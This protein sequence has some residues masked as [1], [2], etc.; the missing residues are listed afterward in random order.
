MSLYLLEGTPTELTCVTGTNTICQAH[1]GA[2]Y[3]L[4]LWQMNPRTRLQVKTK[5][6]AKKPVPPCPQEAQ[7]VMFA[8][9]IRPLVLGPVLK[10]NCDLHFRL[11]FHRDIPL[12]QH[13]FISP[14][15]VPNARAPGESV[16]PFRP[17]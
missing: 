1:K 3:E 10:K 9:M 11:I 17:E 13:E 4:Q 2:D 12:W 6:Y 8:F 5:T 16:Q 7:W 14:A 15:L